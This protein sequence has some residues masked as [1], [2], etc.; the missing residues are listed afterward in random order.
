MSYRGSSAGRLWLQELAEHYGKDRWCLTADVDELLVYPGVEYCDLASLCNYLDIEDSQGLFCVFLDLY[1]DRPL[2]ETI[3]TPGE[4]FTDICN[5]FD[6]DSYVLRPGML[7]PNLG[8]FGGPRGESFLKEDRQGPMMKKVP[9]VKYSDGFSY[10]YSTHSHKNIRLSK[11][12]GSLLHFKFF[13]FFADLAKYEA[14]RGDRRQRGDYAHYADKL[15]DMTC[16]FNTASYQYRQSADLVRLGIMAANKDFRDYCR[17]L[18]GE[19]NPGMMRV[20][21][22]SLPRASDNPPLHTSGV[23]TIRWINT[24]W[25]FANNRGAINH[26]TDGIV[27]GEYTNRN[28]FLKN[29][30]RSVKLI[31]IRG[32]ILRLSLPED[33]V[34]RHNKPNLSLLLLAEG[35]LIHVQSLDLDSGSLTV[36]EGSLVPAI[37]T[38]DISDQDFAREPGTLFNVKLYLVGDEHLSQILDTIPDTREIHPDINDQKFG[39]PVQEL[40]CFVPQ[41]GDHTLPQTFTNTLPVSQA[42]GEG[43]MADALRRKFRST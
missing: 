37:Y 13:E 38:L 43:Q 42:G 10:I 18:Y 27:G 9:L 20:V 14:E 5:N 30:R 36:D 33:L 15:N 34:Y 21:Q 12:T 7:P 41:G 26:L 32:S 1:S 24:I 22:K 6:A 8:I 11:I 4:P 23:P 2:A 35:R 16:F 19:K 29:F 28:R 17:N 31:D 39:E 3:Y 40:F 25:P